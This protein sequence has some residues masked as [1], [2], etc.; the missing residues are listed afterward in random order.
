MLFLRK[1]EFFRSAVSD[2][3]ANNNCSRKDKPI[4]QVFSQGFSFS[5]ALDALADVYNGV[6][7]ALRSVLQ[8]N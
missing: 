1:S 7:G 6:G 4:G 3:Y 5:E 2:R 8:G